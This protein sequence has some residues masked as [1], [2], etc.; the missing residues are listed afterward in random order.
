VTVDT[1]AYVTAARSDIAAGCLEREP[2]PGF[3]LQS[4][5]GE[6]LPILKQILLLLNLGC[7][8]LRIWVFVGNITDKLVLGLD[9]L[10]AYDASVD[11][12]PQ[13]L[14]LA[15]EE[16]SLRSPRAGPVLAA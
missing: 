12:G 16:V 7:R 10:R 1:G 15:E 9:I 3:T 11:I 5:S 13:K 6:S 2:N 14:R 4:V 8:P